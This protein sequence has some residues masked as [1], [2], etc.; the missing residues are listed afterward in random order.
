MTSKMRI[1]AIA[2]YAG[3]EP[4][5][6]KLAEEYPDIDLTVT[7][8]DLKK[9]VEIAQ[10]NFRANYDVIISRGGTA[11]LIQQSVSLPVIEIT[12]SVHDIF[13]HA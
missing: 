4:L 11:K 8:G 7:V 3:M 5:L 1:L 12:T 10:N 9:G 6:I 2:P 13:A